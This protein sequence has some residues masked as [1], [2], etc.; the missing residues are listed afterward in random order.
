MVEFI[1]IALIC[2][3]VIGL[4][5]ASSLGNSDLKYE[6]ISYDIMYLIQSISI[7]SILLHIKEYNFN[8]E[9]F[10]DVFYILLP[11]CASGIG[12]GVMLHFRVKTNSSDIN[13]WA[14]S[15]VCKFG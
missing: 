3:F 4:I 9:F 2:A 11:L 15:V 10:I 5:I 7:I 14:G 6:I 12:V 8:K 1:T 13:L